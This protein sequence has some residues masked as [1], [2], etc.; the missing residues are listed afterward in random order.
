MKYKETNLVTINTAT[1]VY[2]I[3]TNDVTYLKGNNNYTEIFLSDK[4]MI[5]STKCLATTLEDMNDDSIV[6]F[7]RSWAF[8]LNQINSYIKIDRSVNFKN[9]TNIIIPP[10]KVKKFI[11]LFV[12]N[13]IQL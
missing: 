7:G 13:T 10:D 1:R 6:K 5:T 12:K 9:D 2:I 4:P 8:N 11:A 3:D